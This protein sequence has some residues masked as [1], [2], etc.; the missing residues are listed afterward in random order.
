M[1][2]LIVTESFYW[3]KSDQISGGFFFFRE[4]V[5]VPRNSWSA[6]CK[7]VCEDRLGGSGRFH[8]GIALGFSFTWVQY[9]KSH[10]TPADWQWIQDCHRTEFASLASSTITIIETLSFASCASCIS[11]STLIP[12]EGLCFINSQI[13][14]LQPLCFSFK[15]NIVHRR[16]STKVSNKIRTK[17]FS[18]CS[19]RNSG[20]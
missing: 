14:F 12:Y 1:H 7:P 8:L 18:K 6:S 19:I 9:F 20:T 15:V 2:R 3:T 10:P 5:L 4:L 17:H 13:I 11:G 16:P